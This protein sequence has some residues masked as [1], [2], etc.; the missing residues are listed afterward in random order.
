M[1][2]FATVLLVLVF[3]A[4]LFVIACLLLLR[5]QTVP[6]LALS[7]QAPYSLNNS[8]NRSLEIA[9]ANAWYSK[10][11][12]LSEYEL[13]LKQMH[14][15]GFKNLRLLLPPTAVANGEAQAFAS[16]VRKYYPDDVVPILFNGNG[17]LLENMT[18]PDAERYIDA[19]LP[20]FPNVTA[21]E[22]VNEPQDD[23]PDS[24]YEKIVTLIAY[25]HTKTNAPITI[26]FHNEREK[27][28]DRLV[29]HVDIVGFHYYPIMATI[30]GNTL[31]SGGI[32]ERV[33]RL[34]PGLLWVATP[35][36]QSTKQFPVKQTNNPAAD[37]RATLDWLSSYH[38]PFFISEWGYAM[39]EGPALEEAQSVYTKN[40][41]DV[42]KHYENPNF[43]GYEYYG[44][45]DLSISGMWGGIENY[46]RR[47]RPAAE[48][49]P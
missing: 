41:L 39:P 40:M 16:V 24:Y 2:R 36:V 27:A 28:F 7:M 37:L 42:M 34:F 21:W 48:N 11:E 4:V 20:L 10:M 44:F 46:E 14:S 1:A 15:L 12:N 49:F 26:G 31:V 30:F 18:V 43:L 35:Y 25:L 33:I 32:P 47:V 19:W 5:S 8:Q 6:Q 3:L 29:N 13:D 23:M 45:R 17:K 9:G 22:I 38:K